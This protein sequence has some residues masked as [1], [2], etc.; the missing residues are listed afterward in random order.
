M[1]RYGYI[2]FAQVPERVL[3]TS[4][5]VLIIGNSRSNHLGA[6]GTLNHNNNVFILFF[7]S[8]ESHP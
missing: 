4:F 2:R 8:Y 1:N 3:S 6:Q 5:V 7:S